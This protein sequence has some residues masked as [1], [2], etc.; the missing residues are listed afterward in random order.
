M[1]E[2]IFRKLETVWLYLYNI[3]E[4]AKLRDRKQISSWPGM[5][6]KDWPQ[7]VIGVFWGVGGWSSSVSWLWLMYVI[8]WLKLYTTK[9]LVL[10]YVKYALIFFFFTKTVFWIVQGV[11]IWNLNF[12]S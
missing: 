12:I 10:L 1:K 4:E 9:G 7:K 8:V 2:A 3:L 6:E 11:V 5:G